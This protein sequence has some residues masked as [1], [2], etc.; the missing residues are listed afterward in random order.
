MI[1]LQLLRSPLPHAQLHS[2]LGVHTLQ[3]IYASP[4]SRGHSRLLLLCGYGLV[5]V[6]D[7]M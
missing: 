3:Q 7:I 2:S 4:H 5:L 6:I 1:V